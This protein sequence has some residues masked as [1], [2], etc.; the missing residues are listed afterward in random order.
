MAWNSDSQLSSW[1]SLP[2]GVVICLSSLFGDQQGAHAEAGSKIRNALNGPSY[3][4]V[5]LAS[6]KWKPL[7]EQAY[8]LT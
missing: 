3:L 8:F 5:F 4:G 7:A 2:Q 6:D 1:L